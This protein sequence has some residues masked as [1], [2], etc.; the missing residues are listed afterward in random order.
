MSA[1]QEIEY[2]RAQIE[3][4]EAEIKALSGEAA[5]VCHVV[6]CKNCAW[7][8]RLSSYDGHGAEPCKRLCR[9]FATGTDGE[10][11]CSYGADMRG[12]ADGA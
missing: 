5:D 10:D 2:I 6:R 9:Y 4:L 11:F 12:V 1:E 7:W 8:G 3:R